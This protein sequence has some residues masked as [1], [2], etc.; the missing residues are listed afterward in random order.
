MLQQRS[1]Y[2][3]SLLFYAELAI[4]VSRP[5]EAVTYPKAANHPVRRPLCET[6]ILPIA[7]EPAKPWP[8][9]ADGYGFA[10]GYEDEK[11]VE[12]PDTGVC[13]GCP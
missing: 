5:L 7:A 11:G 4:P 1:S 10:E 3:R 6:P 2:L 8:K 9:L 13:E 12:W